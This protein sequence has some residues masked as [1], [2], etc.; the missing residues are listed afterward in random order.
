M[1]ELAEGG[2]VLVVGVGQGVQVLLGGDSRLVRGQMLD[3]LRRVNDL[4]EVGPPER[5]PGLLI[6][7]SSRAAIRDELMLMD[8]W[9][10]P[11]AGGLAL[12]H[13]PQLTLTRRAHAVTVPP[14]TGRG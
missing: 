9:F 5:G 8:A 12:N 10:T 4:L 11:H 3:L 13:R 2:D 14:P 6:R 7:A 1:P